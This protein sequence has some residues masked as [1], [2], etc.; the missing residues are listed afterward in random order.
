MIGLTIFAAL[1]GLMGSPLA[2]QTPDRHTDNV[3]VVLDGS[4]S[5]SGLIGQDSKMYAAK[6]SLRDALLQMPETTRFGLLAFSRNINGWAYELGPLDRVQAWNAIKSIQEGFKTPLGQYLKTGADRLLEEREKQFNYG[7]YRLIVI[8][9]GEATDGNLMEQYARELVGR[10]ITLNVIGVGMLDEHSLKNL[11]HQYVDAQDPEGLSN[12]VTSF[13]AE[14][15]D[16]PR[17]TSA[18]DDSPYELIQAIPTAES[19]L[20]VIDALSAS[21]NEPL[22]S[23]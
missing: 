6:K 12:A 15:P 5:M 11:S 4:G 19:A 2:A 18:G 17:D 21:G 16:V 14:V 20:A 7:T 1:G 3:V 8:T 9:D 10:G 13:L 22:G 23:R